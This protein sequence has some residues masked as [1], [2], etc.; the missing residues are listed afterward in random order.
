MIPMPMTQIDLFT[1]KQPQKDFNGW[2][3]GISIADMVQLCCLAGKNWMLNIKRKDKEGRIWFDSGN[4]VHAEVDN[5]FGQKAFYRIFCWSYGTFLLKP[6]DAPQKTI[7]VPWNFLLIEALRQ[8]DEMAKESSISEDG[9]MATRVLLVDDSPIAC[10]ALR[11]SLSAVEDIEIVADAYNGRQALEMLDIH[12]PDI[13]TLDVNMPIMGGD[14]A[15]MHIMIR[16]PSPVVLVSGLGNSGS[17]QVL[18]FLRLGA[19]DF[20]PKPD[21]SADWDGHEQRLIK[22]LKLARHFHVDSVRR[23]RMPKPPSSKISPG[24]PATR[25]VIVL[26]GLGGILEIQKLIPSLLPMDSLSVVILQDMVGELVAPLSQYLNKYSSMTI[27]ALKDGGPLLSG[28]CWLTCWDIGWHVVADSHGAALSQKEGGLKLS[29]LL[30]TAAAAFGPRLCVVLLSGV[31]I[32]IEDGLLEVSSRGGKIILQ[33]PATCLYPGPI[34][35][36]MA[37]ELEDER[38]DMESM[39]KIIAQWAV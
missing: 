18:E 34:R 17:K 11:R 25:L 30:S 2:I 29:A 10:K 16:S 24:L 32:D 6:G 14:I 37:K 12:H 35:E 27:N 28:Q 39:S 13:L 8:A 4:V 1:D 33:D 23:A 9:D 38:S 5:L 22:D 20:I 31:D 36:I 19:V 15:L 26:G 7:D 21:N 3:E